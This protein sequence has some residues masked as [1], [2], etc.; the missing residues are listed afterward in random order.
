MR[1]SKQASFRTSGKSHKKCGISMFVQKD[2]LKTVRVSS[3]EP[4]TLRHQ[5]PRAS[6]P[7]MRVHDD[8]VVQGVID[9]HKAVIGHRSQE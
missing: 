9:G 1:V 2:S 6:S 3:R 4:M 5:D 7:E 8:R